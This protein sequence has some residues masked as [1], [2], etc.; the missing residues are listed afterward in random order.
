MAHQCLKCGGLFP[1][2]STQ[3]LR[4]CPDCRGTRFFYTSEALPMEERQRLLQQGEADVRTILEGMMSGQIGPPLGA[5]TGSKGPLAVA[6]DP[7]EAPPAPAGPLAM[8]AKLLPGNRLLVRMRRDRM[9][10]RLQKARQR[11]AWDYE[12]PAAPDP[13]TAPPSLAPAKAPP[14][15]APAPTTPAPA[16]PPL[17]GIESVSYTEAPSPEPA[18]PTPGPWAADDEAPPATS[19]AEPED[20]VLMPFDEAP[21]TVRIESPGRYA[22]DVKRLLEEA[23]IVVQKDGS[24]LIHL[25]SLFDSAERRRAPAAR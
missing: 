12:A 2:G 10:R 11:V 21:E 8:E 9:V 4:G 19:D 22:I 13:K 17:R 1:D 23:P 3:I 6:R 15:A 18:G 24:Y 25:P 20:M 14:A 16:A 7:V 5:P